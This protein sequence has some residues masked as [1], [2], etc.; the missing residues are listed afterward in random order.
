MGDAPYT[1]PCAR[2][3]QNFIVNAVATQY[4]DVL[5][6]S[7]GEGSLSASV[8]ELAHTLDVIDTFFTALFTSELLVNLYAHWSSDPRTRKTKHATRQAC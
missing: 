2:A 4:N 7:D 1:L 8:R 3:R 6:P 5:N